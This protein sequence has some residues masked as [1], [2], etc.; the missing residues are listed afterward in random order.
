M[1]IKNIE[2]FI[3]ECYSEY[4]NNSKCRN[5]AKEVGGLIDEIY[6]KRFN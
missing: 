2:E 6:K 3:A 5:I 1:Q 4:V